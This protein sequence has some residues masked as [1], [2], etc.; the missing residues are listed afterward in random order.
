M[1][2]YAGLVT[3]ASLRDELLGSI[4][5]EHTRT[6]RVLEALYGGPLSERRPR[7][8]WALASR[9]RPLRALHHLQIELLRAYRSSAPEP[10]AAR[11]AAELSELLMTVNAI[12]S[13]LRTTG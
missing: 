7:V 12:A 10:S 9:D 13:G 1:K 5:A 6:V 3:D 11:A 8:R 4:L 2:S